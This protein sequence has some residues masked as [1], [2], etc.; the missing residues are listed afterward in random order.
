[1]VTAASLTLTQ[2][3]TQVSTA[4]GA[5]G[6]GRGAFP[7]VEVAGLGSNGAG[8]VELT[9]AIQGEGTTVLDFD[10]EA[11]GV[12]PLTYR[13]VAGTD[14]RSMAIEVVAPA[15]HQALRRAG[16]DPATRQVDVVAHSMGG[17]LMRYLVER[18]D[19]ASRVDD[20]VMVATPNHGSAV[21]GWE[22]GPA[23][24]GCSGGSVTA[25]TASTTRC[26]AS[27]PS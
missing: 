19:W 14:I 4:V 22:R 18:D 23:T 8:F 25:T 16:L 21:I 9:R 13:P 1:M 7:V 2:L 27:R 24:R 10:A 5:V 20:L 12:Q 15:I 11:P 3:D 26:R 6:V 17:L